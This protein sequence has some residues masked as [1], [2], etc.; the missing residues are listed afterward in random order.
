MTRVLNVLKPQLPS[1]VFLRGM[2]IDEHYETHFGGIEIHD[3]KSDP[4]A[5]SVCHRS[6]FLIKSIDLGSFSIAIRSIN[7]AGKLS[8]ANYFELPFILAQCR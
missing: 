5:G 6:F 3:I 4:I 8:N 7:R 2:Q 1:G